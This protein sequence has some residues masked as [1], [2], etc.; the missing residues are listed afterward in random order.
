MN[1]NNV[2]QLLLLLDQITAKVVLV[3]ESLNNMSKEDES[4]LRELLAKQRAKNDALYEEVAE[5]LKAKV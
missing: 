4:T 5:M 3:I 1:V 2:V